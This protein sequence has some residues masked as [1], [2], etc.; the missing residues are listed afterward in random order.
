MD[1]RV[2][3]DDLEGRLDEGVEAVLWEDWRQFS[4]GRWKEPVFAP[5][6]PAANP[7]KVDWP[8]LRINAALADPDL[9]VLH[10]MAECSRILSSA[11]GLVLAVRANYGTPIMAAPLGCEVFI[12]PDETDTL[13]A[14]KPLPDGSDGVKAILDRGELPV[15]H[16]YLE[17]VMT[18]GWRLAAIGKEYPKIG[19]H[20]HVYHPDMQ[21]SMDILEMVWGSSFF[22]EVYDRPQMVHDFLDLITRFYIK[23]LKKWQEII[24]PRT[25]GLAV[26][27]GMVHRGTIMLRE[28]S[29]MN[30]SPEIFDEFIR[31]YEQRL[32][33]AFGGGAMH[34]CGRVDH[35]TRYLARMPGLHAFNMSQPHLND[36]DKVLQETVGQGLRLIGL[37]RKAA[38]AA[39]ERGVA[40]QG[41]VHCGGD[42]W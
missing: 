34:A 41:R 42:G 30:L 37:D 2:Y 4:V 11:G 22:L 28:D 19:R 24:P 26:H 18:M 12:M 15:D 38:A 36:M 21:G 29:A 1:L 25:D 14:A 33:N 10:Q 7:P 16:P 31:P 27:W 35:F 6:R 5:R 40:L 23:V 39:M 9:M 8:K 32:L 17:K 3:L 13:P 20:V